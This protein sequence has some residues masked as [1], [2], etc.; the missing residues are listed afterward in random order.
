MD[1]NNLQTNDTT[2]YNGSLIVLC[3]VTRRLLFVTRRLVFVACRLLFVT[4]RLVFVTRRLVFVTRRLVFVTCRLVFVTRRLVFA[5]RR[6]VFVTRRV[7]N[8]PYIK[9]SKSFIFV[10]PSETP[11]GI[12]FP[13]LISYINDDNHGYHN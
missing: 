4:C 13:Q 1:T 11:T 5:T 10:S 7:Q 12:L 2:R 6:L 8:C 3:C 9:F